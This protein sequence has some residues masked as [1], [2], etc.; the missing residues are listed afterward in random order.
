MS[1]SQQATELYARRDQIAAE[2]AQIDAQL[3]RLRTQY[4][5]D[6]ST[7]GINPTNFRRAVEKVPA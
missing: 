5:V 6:T 7:Y 1:L 3:N 4:M 2:L